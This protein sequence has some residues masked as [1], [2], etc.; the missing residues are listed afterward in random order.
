VVQVRGDKN[1]WFSR[2]SA[3]APAM[4]FCD[5]D[6]SYEATA[7]DIGFALKVGTRIVCGHDYCAQHPGTI[8]AVD[9]HGGPSS[10]TGTVWVLQHSAAT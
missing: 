4:V 5:A 1:E 6:H 10:L 3:E 8:R 9:E 2:Y 7:R